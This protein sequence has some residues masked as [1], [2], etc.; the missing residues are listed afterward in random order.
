MIS[1]KGSGLDRVDAVEQRHGHAS[2]G[3]STDLCETWGMMRDGV[4]VVPR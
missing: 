4:A 3:P 1:P 2:G